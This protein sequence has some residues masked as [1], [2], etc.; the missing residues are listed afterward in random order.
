MANIFGAKQTPALT[1]QAKYEMKYNASR[2]NLLLVVAFT[3]IN[4]IIAIFGG[5]SYFLFSAFIPYYVAVL[6]ALIGGKLPAEYYDEGFVADSTVF[7]IL[8]VIAIVLIALYVVFW[9]LSKKKVGWLIASLVFFVIDTIMMFALGGISIE[10]IV[11]ILFHAWVIYY[12]VTGVMAHY[13]L[14]AIPEEPAESEPVFTVESE[15][16]K[17]NEVEH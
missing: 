2:L 17:E 13:K 4:V 3:A 5:E 6:G 8:T 1:P 9:L 10:M 11:D 14:K 16:E 7:T 12:L 15:P